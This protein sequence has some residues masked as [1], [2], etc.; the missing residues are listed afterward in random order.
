M[1]EDDGLKAMGQIILIDEARI[2]DQSS[3]THDNV[4]NLSH[5]QDCRLPLN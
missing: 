1:I 3:T 2:R 5:F 4:Q